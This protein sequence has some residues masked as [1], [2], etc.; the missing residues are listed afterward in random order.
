MKDKRSLNIADESGLSI[1]VT[2][3]GSIA[4]NPDLEVGKIIALKNSRV[5]EF[6]GR[7][8]NCGDDHTGVYIDPDHP[9]AIEL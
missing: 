3:W 6:G 8:L 9:R 2:L 4:H 7:S 5:S 1:N